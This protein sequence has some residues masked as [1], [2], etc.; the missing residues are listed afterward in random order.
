METISVLEYLK[1][2]G[3]L[4]DIAESGY[5]SIPNAISNLEFVLEDMERNFWSYADK[6][7]VSD[8]SNT[9]KV[10]DYSGNYRFYELTE[11]ETW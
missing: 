3:L 4:E 7:E 9:V 2:T 5:Y 11:T 10:E 6:D 1:R 8:P